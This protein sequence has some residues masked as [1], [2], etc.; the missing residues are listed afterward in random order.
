MIAEIKTMSDR[1]R[2]KRPL[3]AFACL[4]V[5]AAVHA[6]AIKTPRPGDVR[7]EGPLAVKADEFI[8]R[9]IVDQRVRDNIFEEARRAFVLRDD[10]E[11]PWDGQWRGEFWGKSMISAA[12]AAEYLGDAELKKWI[13]GECRRLMATKDGEG[14]IGS[15]SSMTNCATPPSVQAAHKGPCTNWNLWCRKYAIWGLFMA[16]AVTG[17]RDILDAAAAQLEHLIDMVRKNGMRLEDTGHYT[18]NGMPTMSILKP[19]LMVYSATG[20]GKFLEFAR[21]IVRGW[22]RDDG[23]A[24]N[25]LR[26]AWNGRPL[27]AWYPEPMRWAKTY[28]MLSCLDGLVEYHRVTGERRPLDAVAAI[29]DNLAATDGNAIGGL[30]ISDRLLGAENFAYASTEVCDVVHWIRLNIDLYL[31][32]GEERYLDTVEFS[33]FNAFLASI[34][35]DSG[36]TPLIVRDAGRHRNSTGQCG[37]AYNHCCVDNAARTFFDVASVAVTRGKDGVFRVNLY[38][39][40]SVRL[41]GVGFSIRGDYP[42]RGRVTVRVEGKAEGGAKPKIRFRKPGWCSRLDVTEAA[43]GEYVLD[44]D[45]NPRIAERTLK[46]SIAPAAEAAATQAFGADRYILATDPDLRETIPKE[47]YATVHWGPLVLARSARLGA[48]REELVSFPSVNGKGYRVTLKPMSA[49]GVYAPFELELS[50]P[51]AETIRTKACSYESA[52][53]DPASRN[54]YIFSIRF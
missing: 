41:D 34:F 10:D 23:R 19:T 20:N 21:E 44:F 17:E 25:F 27:H 37:Y 39:D 42:A 46:P 51:G 31:V 14:Y 45:M 6:D 12:R 33:Y 29:R 26:N 2:L 8:K 11:R 13:V 48:G 36:W 5:F 18:L 1:D 24:P 28:E 4:G 43:D 9:R 47:P 38:Q 54:G 15:Y 53:D 40:A 22:D 49:H 30:G 3:L 35:R 7:L 16:Y 32:T 52:S 50:K